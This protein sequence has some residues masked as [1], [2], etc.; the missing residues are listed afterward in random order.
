MAAKTINSGTEVVDSLLEGGY[1]TDIVTTIYGPAGSGKTNIVLLA[2]IEIAN[3]GK[4]VIYIDTEGGFSVARLNQLTSSSK[5]ILSNI[6]FL[7]PTKFSEQ[8]KAFEKLKDVVNNKEIGLVIVDTIA[9]L[10]RLELGKT[11]DIYE[12]NR[13]LG[14][15]IAYL[16][17]IARKKNIPVLITNQ[18]Y[19]NF[20]ERNKIKMVGGDI[21][22][23]GSKC[24]IELQITPNSKRRA[25][26]KKHRS[27]PEEKEVMFEIKE[28][29]LK[30]IK[31]TK[32][33]KIF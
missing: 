2:A 19:S 1:E 7:K 20:D 22:R 16:T 14:K 26:L 10:Y 3:Q 8:K 17:E 15:Q 4:K 12:V 11:E 24:L 18:V 25:I 28:K 6:L 21:I 30:L 23:Y 9:M 29:E 5:K 33:F 27:M 31:K 32:S 13:E